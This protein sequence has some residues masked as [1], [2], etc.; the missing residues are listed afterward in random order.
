MFRL[1]PQK[2]K[3]TQDESQWSFEAT[4]EIFQAMWQS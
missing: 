4:G 3:Y 1:F 2:D